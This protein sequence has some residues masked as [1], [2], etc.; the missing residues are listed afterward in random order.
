[1]QNA[2]YVAGYKLSGHVA[3]RMTE[4]SV[5]LGAINRLIQFGEK[6]LFPEQNRVYYTSDE[7]KIVVVCSI[8]ADGIGSKYAEPSVVTVLFADHRRSIDYVKADI[9]R[10]KAK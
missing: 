8:D 1:M 7:N 9:R 6:T 4:R 5:S 2:L 3:L 10:R